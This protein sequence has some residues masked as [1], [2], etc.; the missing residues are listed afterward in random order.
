[1]WNKIINTAKKNNIHVQLIS[2]PFSSSA[3]EIIHPQGRID[4]FIHAVLV[5]K[6]QFGNSL[7]HEIPESLFVKGEYNDFIHPNTCGMLKI[8]DELA[9]LL[10]ML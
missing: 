3:E 1:M 6:N 5:L 4:P 7:L 2:I 8:T 10:D 9:G